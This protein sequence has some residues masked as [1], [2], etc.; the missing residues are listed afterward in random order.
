[1]LAGVS[2]YKFKILLPIT[3][4]SALRAASLAW[5][6]VD[7]PNPRARGILMC[8]RTLAKYDLRSGLRVFFSPVVPY[9]ETQYM[10]P[11][12]I[13]AIFRSLSGGVMGEMT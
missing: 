9:L 11:V 2:S 1:M 8:F 5:A 3:M 4:M 7:I 12:A 10:N 6:G 13:F